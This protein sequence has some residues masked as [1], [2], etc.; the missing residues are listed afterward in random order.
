[1]TDLTSAQFMT[2]AENQLKDEQQV[3][4]M[5]TGKGGISN[6]LDFLDK[7][8]KMLN[9][10]GVEAI[11][12]LDWLGEG[13]EKT[14]LK[15][16]C[17]A[18]IA[19]ISPVAQRVAGMPQSIDVLITL[20][21]DDWDGG[22]DVGDMMLQGEQMRDDNLDQDKREKAKQ[23]YESQKKDV[24]DKLLGTLGKVNLE[25]Q[26]I[27]AELESIKVQME[28]ARKKIPEI[29]DSAVRDAVAYRR[30]HEDLDAQIGR[31]IADWIIGGTNFA[32]SVIH[33]L[34]IEPMTGSIVG[35]IHGALNSLKYGIH[36]L[37]Q[38]VKRLQLPE[39]GK[40]VLDELGSTDMFE[41]KWNHVFEAILAAEDYIGAIPMTGTLASIVRD[42]VKMLTKQ[43]QEALFVNIEKYAKGEEE[44]LPALGEKVLK[45]LP[46][47][48]W[49]AGGELIKV[50]AEG[51]SPMTMI[52][53]LVTELIAPALGEIWGRIL[54]GDFKAEVVTKADIE[55]ILS[56]LATNI[57]QSYPVLARGVEAAEEGQSTFGFDMQG[58]QTQNDTNLHG[59]VAGSDQGV[60]FFVAFDVKTFRSDSGSGVALLIGQGHSET[61]MDVMNQALGGP[62]GATGTIYCKKGALR[63][64]YEVHGLEGDA[65]DWVKRYFAET[66]ITNKNIVFK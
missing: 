48:I 26:R 66:K 10:A 2:W 58:A 4:T 18:A 24:R 37:I 45:D 62:N 47:M 38:G 29:I 6:A 44:L 65:R 33:T 22:I 19:A 16:S 60:P 55:D 43:A 34:D 52:L 1:M 28:A 11:N 63:D 8:K 15:S 42:A 46:D 3:L 57:A 20:I 49:K 50:V 61:N 17:N 56:E 21:R 23:T 7:S 35:A 53:G 40:E 32:V 64:T 30:A 5:L 41:S 9:D 31:Q 36:E 54:P 51:D 14:F 59:L 27:K 25:A 13:A 39:D 12:F